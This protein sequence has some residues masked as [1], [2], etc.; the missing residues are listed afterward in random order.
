MGRTIGLAAVALWLLTVAAAAFVF[1]KGDTA[2]GSDGRTSVHL[3]PAQRDFVLGEMRSLLTAVGQVSQAL[4]EGND[5]KVAAAARQVGS[6]AMHDAPPTLLAKLPL[7]FKV[8]AKGLHSGF[9]DLAAA[10]EKGEPAAALEGRLAGL[11]D[12]CSACHQSYRF[13]AV[14]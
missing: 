7:D 11:V 2:P 6:A 12:R 8:S 10:A 5:A 13:D 14:Q 3:Q 9:D 1:I 4:A